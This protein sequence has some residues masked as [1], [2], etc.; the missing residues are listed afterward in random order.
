MGMPEKAN[1]NTKQ[2]D[3]LAGYIF[4]R[5]LSY[6]TEHNAPKKANDKIKHKI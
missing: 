5:K 3:A 2:T 6:T 4:N 1:W